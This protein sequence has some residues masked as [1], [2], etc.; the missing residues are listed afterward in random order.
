[1]MKLICNKNLEV[2]EQINAELNGAQTLS[3]ENNSETPDNSS[4]GI[5][6]Q[7][8]KNVVT[9]L[10]YM[11]IGMLG[12]FLIIGIIIGVVTILNKIKAK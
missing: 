2:V 7:P 12:I 3:T 5:K 4:L 1:M 9:S 8:M 10:K 11:G 6:I